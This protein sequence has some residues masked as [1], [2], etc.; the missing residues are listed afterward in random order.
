[1]ASKH[2]SG[3]VQR[4]YSC[5][6]TYRNV[7]L[8]D[9]IHTKDETWLSGGDTKEETW[10]SVETNFFRLSRDIWPKH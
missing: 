8:T 9:V 6:N 4:A 2:Q 5:D 3:L 1:M 7:C 10:F